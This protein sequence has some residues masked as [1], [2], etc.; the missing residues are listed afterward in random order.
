[1][2]EQKS[3][4]QNLD[5]TLVGVYLLLVL[6]GWMNIYAA[7]YNEEHKS[8]LDL[9]QNYGKQAIWIGGALILAGALPWSQGTGNSMDHPWPRTSQ[10][11][12]DTTTQAAQL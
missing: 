4:L 11:L 7:V 12:R 6:A 2:R 3:I 9:T 5:W 8:L 1:M 10:A